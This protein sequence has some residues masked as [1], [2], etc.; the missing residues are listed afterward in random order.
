MHAAYNP[1]AAT[2]SHAAKVRGAAACIE[3]PTRR[4]S[5][6]PRMN[7]SKLSMSRIREIAHNRHRQRP[8]CT[9]SPCA[10]CRRANYTPDMLQHTLHFVLGLIALITGA[11][12]LVRAASKLA[13]SI[14]ISPRFTGLTI[15]SFGNSAPELAVSV[16][17]AR[18]GK[19]VRHCDLQSRMARRVRMPV[20]ARASGGRL[21]FAKVTGTQRRATNAAAGDTSGRRRKSAALPGRTQHRARARRSHA[22]W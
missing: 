4:E 7:T 5:V 1:Q 17:A 18:A 14:G 3:K 12:L 16:S 9:D 10:T 20:P 22:P 8:T 15:V 13:R 21:S 19:A 2:E 11:G 6:S